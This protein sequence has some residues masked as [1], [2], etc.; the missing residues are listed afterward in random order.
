M[1]IANKY[2]LERPGSAGHGVANHSQHH[3]FSSVF[4]LFFFFF[5][6]F[7]F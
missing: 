7:F 1:R 3:M 5:F 2:S 6:F 4:F